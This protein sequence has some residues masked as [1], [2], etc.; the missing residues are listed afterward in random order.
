MWFTPKSRVRFQVGENCG[1]TQ[2]KTNSWDGTFAGLLLDRNGEISKSNA[3]FVYLTDSPE[4]TGVSC[5]CRQVS[6]SDQRFLPLVRG[7]A[8]GGDASLGPQRPLLMI[9]VPFCIAAASA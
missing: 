4:H 9:R 1:A 7:P 2:R 3:V 5:S 6:G 8:V